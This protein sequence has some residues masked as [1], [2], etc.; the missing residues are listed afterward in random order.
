MAYKMKRIIITSPDDM[1]GEDVYIPRLIDRGAFAVHLRKPEWSIARYA[2]LLRMIPA[3][4]HRYIVLHDHYALC[5]DF[6]LRGIHLNRR[7]PSP[8][9]CHYG[10]ISCSCHTLEEVIAAKPRKDYVFLSPIFDSISKAGYRSAFTAR[11]LN[12]AARRGII[13][14]KVIALG[15]VTEDKTGL[16]AQWRFGGYAMLGAVWNNIINT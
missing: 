3:E 15:G 9:D 14:E 7:N 6:A 1:P 12:E 11:R 2:A 16:L 13:D 10:H 4:Y 5:R 8:P